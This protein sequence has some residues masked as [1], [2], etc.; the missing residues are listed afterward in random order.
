MTTPICPSDKREI[1]HEAVWSLSTAK[2]G[3]GKLLRSSCVTH[4]SL[5]ILAVQRGYFRPV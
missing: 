1:G 5:F 2:P 4:F 3:N